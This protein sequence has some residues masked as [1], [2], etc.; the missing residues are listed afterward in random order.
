MS[1]SISP[2]YPRW[3][4]LAAARGDATAV[5]ETGSGQRHSF[6]SLAQRAAAAPR[7]TAPVISEETGIDLLTTTLR[8]WRDGQPLLA[9]E[10]GSPPVAIDLLDEL[11]PNIIHIKRSSGSTGSPRL[12]LFKAEQLAADVD[13]IVNAMNLCEHRWN[14]AVISLAHSY[15]FS[16]LV[17]PLLL[18]G[19]PLLLGK[20]P[21]PAAVDRELATVE[22]DII[23]PAV[24]AMWKA[25]LDAGILDS[26]RISL[27]ISAGAPLTTALEGQ[28]FER[29]A[30]KIH[31][32]YGSSECGGISYDQSDV[33]RADSRSV[34]TALD[35]VDLS[36]GSGDTLI[37]RSAAVAE[38]YWPLGDT[39]DL[40][41]GCFQTSD[42]VDLH[43]GEILLNGRAGDSINVAGRKVSPTEIESLL[44]ALPGVDHCLVFGVPSADPQRV[45]EIVACVAGRADKPELIDALRGS[46]RSWQIPRH[47]WFPADLAPDRRG[48]LS[49]ARW[50]RRYLSR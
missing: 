2:L 28:V 13:Q 42:I 38:S 37:V 24:P 9:I 19:V 41:D 22:G 10:P 39:D 21:L 47:W 20:S 48:K 25:W 31:N 11:P 15:G 45:E 12:I 7:A 49:R 43:N 16:N 8:C 30:L 4:E 17:L 36:T 35:G 14:F 23:L 34:G 44:A 50:R 33:P 27:A 29:C 40:S 46:L 18:H 6:A 32:F 26:E 3:L 1:H 5:L